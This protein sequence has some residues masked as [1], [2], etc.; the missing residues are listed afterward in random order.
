MITSLKPIISEKS[1]RLAAKGQYMFEVELA[2]NKIIIAKA[3]KDQ[4]KVDATEVKTALIK[5]KVKRYR[6]QTGQRSNTKRAYVSLK[7][8]QKIGAFAVESA[9]K[10]T[11]P[12]KKDKK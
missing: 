6:G 9:D 12:A 2:S 7:A 10:E 8:G 4:F 5:G 3:V 1:M 11:K